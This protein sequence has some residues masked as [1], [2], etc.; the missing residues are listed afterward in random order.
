VA[1]LLLQVALLQNTS[2]WTLPWHEITDA[3]GLAPLTVCFGADKSP[4]VALLVMQVAL[5]QN[6][7][8]LDV[9][10]ARNAST[11]NTGELDISQLWNVRVPRLL[12][13]LKHQSDD[14]KVLR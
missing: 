3:L 8:S 10:L 9:A 2:L 11:Y 5:L 12:Q 7:S 14:G 6:T 4:F 13:T 1:L